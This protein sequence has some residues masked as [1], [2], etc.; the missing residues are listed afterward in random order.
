MASN[1]VTY[2]IP[3]PERAAFKALSALTKTS[4]AEHIRKYIRWACKLA[5]VPITEVAAGWKLEDGTGKLAA[6]DCAS[7]GAAPVMTEGDRCES[8]ESRES[9]GE[10]AVFGLTADG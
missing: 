4:E 1:R 8:H 10:I 6:P 5:G 3:E 7:P 9:P 2:T